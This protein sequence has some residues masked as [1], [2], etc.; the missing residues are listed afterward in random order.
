MKVIF[1][2]GAPVMLAHGGT[3]IQIEQTKAGLES[4]G[5]EVEY[6]RWWDKSQQG[7]LIHY[8]GTASTYYLNLARA[9]GRPVAMTT[10]FS[11]A[12]NRSDTRLRWQGRLIQAA[13]RFPLA[14]N[15]KNQLTWRTYPQATHNVVG[16][17]CERQ[18]LE[19]VFH[20]IPQNIS[21]VPLGLPKI[22]LE[23][24]PGRRA[25]PHLI[26]IGT[27]TRVKNSLALAKM[28]HA[29]QTPILFVGKPYNE[30]DAY[31]KSFKNLVDGKLVKHQP[32]TD[33]KE[34][35]VRLLQSA[36]GFVLMSHYEN[37]CLS[38]H[39]AVACGLPLLVQDQKWSRERFG[40][41]VRY[42]RHIGVSAENVEALKQFYA[43]AP[44]LSPPAIKLHSWVEVAQELKKVYAQVLTG[45]PATFAA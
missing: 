32:H 40:K 35:M 24:G 34:E 18:V 15:V 45:K 42:F 41:Q 9:S 39:E 44:D 38:A 3:H 5:V 27:I 8:F 22:F 11:A 29:A 4:I 13:L 36:R 16:L 21:V 33:S 12:C 26:C 37:W 10:F 7:D 25:G 20:V 43:A 19:N 31:W 14:N 17:E 2:N 6:M 28:A 23:A 30:N 1:D